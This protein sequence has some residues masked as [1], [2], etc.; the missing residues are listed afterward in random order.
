MIFNSLVH[1]LF[2][3][4]MF[5]FK[6]M[7][8]FGW[9]ILNHSYWPICYAVFKILWLIL[10][11]MHQM[12]CRFILN[13]PVLFQQSL[14]FVRV[15]IALSFPKAWTFACHLRTFAFSSRWNIIAA[16]YT[17]IAKWSLQYCKFAGLIELRVDWYLIA[18]INLSFFELYVTFILRG[19]SINVFIGLILQMLFLNVFFIINL[20]LI[21]NWC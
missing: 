5:L 8:F 18:S 9:L 17:C 2:H 11:L 13:F 20:L 3:S 14:R 7:I 4:L 1:Y 12:A 15:N 6:L 10:F 16:F 21:S 19:F